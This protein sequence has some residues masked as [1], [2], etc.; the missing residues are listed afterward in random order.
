MLIGLQVPN[1]TWLGGPEKLGNTL[2]E[3]AST[4]D[5]AGFASLWVMDHFFQIPGMGPPE[6]EMLESW[7]TLGFLANVTE[8]I[9][10]GTLV[11]GVT[12]RHPGILA[13]MATTLNV[14]SGGRAYLGIGAAWYEREHLGLGVLFPPRRERFQRLEEALQIVLQMWSGNRDAYEGQ[15]YRLTETLNVPSPL[16]RP[17]P[18]ILIGGGG[19]RKTLRL[20]A[21][22][23][24]AVTVFGDPA[25]VRHQYKVLYRWCQVED[26][27]YDALERTTLQTVDLDGQHDEKSVEQLLQQF[28]AFAEA[29][30]QHLIVNMPN[31]SHITPLE[32]FGE[33]IIPAVASF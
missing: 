5:A 15:Y 18:P 23:A 9:R 11:T 7:T 31:V 12:Y 32:F 27:P 20:A 30:V 22:Y 13:K 24:D 3:I 21:R 28:R 2:A 1:F 16:A 8:R 10:L 4:A 33:R 25:T 14:L 29:S 17:H 26:R 19:E 6:S